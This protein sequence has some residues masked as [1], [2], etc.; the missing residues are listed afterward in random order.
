MMTPME[1]ISVTNPSIRLGDT[2][3]ARAKAIIDAFSAHRELTVKQL[4]AACH[5]QP[6]TAIMEDFLM[7]GLVKEEVREE[8][9]ITVLTRDR[10]YTNGREIFPVF[11]EIRDPDDPS[12]TYVVTLQC[13][14][15]CWLTTRPNV[16]KQIR[17][18]RKY[19]TWVG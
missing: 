8:E 6:V 14:Q 9:T 3:T 5:W 17:V 10:V 16:P 12:V 7:A 13:P 2:M 19:Y 18:R 4:E 15:G 11:K 1:I